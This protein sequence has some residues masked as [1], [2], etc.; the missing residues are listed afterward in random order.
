M[1]FQ[2]KGECRLKTKVRRFSIR[3]KILIPITTLITA[4]CVIL[5]VNAYNR[6][7]TGMIQLGVEEAQM[8][9]AMAQTVVNGDD[10]AGMGEDFENTDEYQRILADLRQVKNICGIAFL[11]TLHTDDN[12]SLYYGIDTDESAGQRHPG[13]VYENRYAE[14]A[15]VFAGQEY[16]QDYIQETI[17]GTLISAYLPI[18]DSAG[19]VVAVLG[20]DYDASYVADRIRAARDSVLQISAI[21]LVLALLIVNLL[22]GSIMK[23]LNK[24]DHKIYDL[25]HNEG[26]L[27]QKLDISSGDELE[28]IAGNVNMLLEYI[29]GIMLNISANATQLG[30]STGTIAQSLVSAKDN[31]SD[32]SATMEQM[33]AAMEETSASL[34]QVNDSVVNITQSIGG[35]A[36]KASAERDSA[37][38]IMEKV[39]TIY[40]AA[41]T[42]RTEAARLAAEMSENVKERIQRSKAVEQI[43]ALTAEIINITDQTSL[44]ALNANIEA[45]RAG[46]AGKGFAVVA[47]EIGALANNSARAA[48][49]IQ[50]VSQEVIHAVNELA[51]ES[52]QMIRF[53]NETA[54]AGYERLLDNST[55]YKNDVGRL[56]ET[57]KDFADESRNLNENIDSIKEAV[58]AVNVAVEESAKGVVGVT[59]MASDM[60]RSMENIKA[61]AENNQEVAGQLEAEVGKFKL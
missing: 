42:D 61:E 12:S 32:I 52:E 14:F 51:S 15:D 16:V 27:T 26:D 19:K 13:D 4:M 24:V 47:N 23:S 34:Y 1:F 53:M 5:G 9:A 17:D 44:L 39:Q 37:V 46:E 41:E 50:R 30:E 45:A 3:W 8:A 43:D 48:E 57:M 2:M 56:S 31:I 58:D 18:W 55:D 49:G 59:E 25:V 7:K 10:L 33:S 60:T 54:M 20:C 6:M 36:G 22:V 28:R 35:I 38:M 29:R 40:E 21:C 11:Y